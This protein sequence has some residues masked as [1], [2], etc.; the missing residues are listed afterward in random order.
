MRRQTPAGGSQAN[1]SEKDV[2][3]YN[4]NKAFIESLAK[5]ES[6]QWLAEADEA[7]ESAIALVGEM[8]ILIPLA[9]LIDKDAELARLE[10]EIGKLQINID[11][12]TTKLVNKS[13]VDKAPAAVV[14]K[15]RAR[16]AE[17]SKAV[18]QLQQQSEKISAL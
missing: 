9:G 2:A 6:S 18:E 10:K 12:T 17:M 8:K 13:F 11:K 5:V 4:S 7:P 3:L 14:E 16:L 15:E 1:A